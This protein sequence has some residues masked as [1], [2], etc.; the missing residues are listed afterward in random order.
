MYLICSNIQ[1][2]IGVL[3]TVVLVSTSLELFW[4]NN[5]EWSTVNVNHNTFNKMYF[6]IGTIY[7]T[8]MACIYSDTIYVYCVILR[9]SV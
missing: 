8:I 6:T 9:N 1:I 3:I 7:K 2:N 5:G 4:N